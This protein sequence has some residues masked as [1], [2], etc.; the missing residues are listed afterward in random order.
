M[1]HVKILIE[2]FFVNSV[3]RRIFRPEGSDVTEEW[4]KLHDKELHLVLF[5]EYYEDG[6]MKYVQMCC[7]CTCV[8]EMR[9]VYKA[10]LRKPEW[11]LLVCR[12]KHRWGEYNIKT[13]L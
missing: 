11:K 4:R 8:Q 5:I 2:V 6:R 3:L 13:V 10:L 12:M 9:N 1:C 7:A